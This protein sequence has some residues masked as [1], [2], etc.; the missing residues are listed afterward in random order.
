M[1]DKIMQCDVFMTLSITSKWVI[2]ENKG[3]GK[4]N[5]SPFVEVFTCC[6]LLQDVMCLIRRQVWHES[7]GIT[8]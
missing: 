2:F 7:S 1:P 3:E 8:G 4:A 6:H 5:M